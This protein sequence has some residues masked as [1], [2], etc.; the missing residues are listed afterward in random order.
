MNDDI[1][2]LKAFMAFLAEQGYCKVTPCKECHFWGSPEDK[3]Y[4]DPV[5]RCRKHHIDVWP[6]DYCGDAVKVSDHE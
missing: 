3:Q 2:L 5:R 1:Q 4:K 6:D